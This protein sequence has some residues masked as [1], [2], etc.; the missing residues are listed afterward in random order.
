MA[1]LNELRFAAA[2]AAHK[3]WL[4]TQQLEVDYRNH[5]LI[6]DEWEGEDTDEWTIYSGN[7]EAEGK[8][9]IEFKPGTSEIVEVWFEVYRG[10][11]M[12]GPLDS[13]ELDG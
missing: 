3:K 5:L 9:F 1:H 7:G 12:C 13:A 6:D 11:F 2:Q 8:F 4:D 10:P